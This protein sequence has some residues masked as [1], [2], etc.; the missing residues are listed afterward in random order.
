VNGCGTESSF[1]LVIHGTAKI[2]D[3]PGLLD[4]T[5]ELY[6]KRKA[7]HPDSEAL[8]DKIWTGTSV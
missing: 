6:A 2:G 8:E 1:S 5:A 4:K 3:D 7:G